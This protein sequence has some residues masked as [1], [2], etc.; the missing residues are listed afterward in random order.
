MLKALFAGALMVGA[1][2]R[3]G[4]AITNEVGGSKPGR[5]TTPD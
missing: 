5:M 1:G 3:I 4:V 2:V